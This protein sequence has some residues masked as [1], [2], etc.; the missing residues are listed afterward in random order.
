M[1]GDPEAGT[2]DDGYYGS[3][4]GEEEPAAFDSD[5]SD[6]SDY[7]PEFE[8]DKEDGEI[9]GVWFRFHPEPPYAALLQSF[10]EGALSGM[11][12]LR[13]FTVKVGRN[14]NAP[15]NLNY[16]PQPEDEGKG[17]FWEVSTGR[18]FDTSWEMPPELRRSLKGSDGNIGLE[19]DLNNKHNDSVDM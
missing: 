11:P 14:S 17:P 9:P 10:V 5:D 12:K 4:T 13:S 6:T 3:Y 7:A 19:C 2:I 18:E 8:W 15:L 16:V 1:S